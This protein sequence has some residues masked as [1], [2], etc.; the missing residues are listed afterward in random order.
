M[1]HDLV[2]TVL[3]ILDV[4]EPERAESDARLA[5]RSVLPLLRAAA[6]ETAGL[7]AGIQQAREG[8]DY[9]I[10]GWGDYAAVRSRDW[11]YIVNFERPDDNPCLFDLRTDPA[12]Q[13]NVLAAHPDVVARYRRV[14]EHFLGQE[15]PARL[16]DRFA[17]SQAP[18]RVYY[19]SQASR[20]MQESGFV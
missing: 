18:C 14:L 8:R 3:D 15:L 9:A 10:T 12:E 19:H 7:E 4:P 13:R 16:P 17:P 20:V 5:G 1:S 2:P 6:G 11:N